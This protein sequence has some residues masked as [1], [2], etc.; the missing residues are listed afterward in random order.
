MNYLYYYSKIN[1]LIQTNLI[2]LGGSKVKLQKIG[3][4][5]VKTGIAVSLWYIIGTV[6]S[7]KSNVCRLGC[8]ASVQDTG[9]RVFKVR[10]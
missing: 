8:V 5:T 10:I 9:K 4:R 3:M 6:F 2:S 1:S 7:G